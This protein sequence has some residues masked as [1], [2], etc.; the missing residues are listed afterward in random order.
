MM[1]VPRVIALE[2][3]LARIYQTWSVDR[4]AMMYLTRLIDHAHALIGVID[5]IAIIIMKS[6]TTV[7]SYVDREKHTHI[8]RVDGCMYYFIM[9]AFIIHIGRTCFYSLHISIIL[10]LHM[11]RV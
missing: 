10:L 1:G 5:T 9:C 11:T 4:I 7:Q 3:T 6:A 2:R 8:Y